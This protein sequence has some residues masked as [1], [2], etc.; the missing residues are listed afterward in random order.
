V[1]AALARHVGRG[2]AV[3]RVRVLHVVQTRNDKPRNHTVS[4]L[5]MGRWEW[6]FGVMQITRALDS[7]KTPCVK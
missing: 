6:P 7:A 5:T 4:A 2:P 3:Y 1:P